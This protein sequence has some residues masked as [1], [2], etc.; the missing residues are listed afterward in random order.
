MVSRGIHWKYDDFPSTGEHLSKGN[1]SAPKK[2]LLR[3][4]NTV[5][6]IELWA[7]NHAASLSRTNQGNLLCCWLLFIHNCLGWSSLICYSLNH[8]LLLLV[9]AASHMKT[10][11]VIVLGPNSCTA[12]ICPEIETG[13]RTCLAQVM[14]VIQSE[15]KIWL[16]AGLWDYQ[17][18]NHSPCNMTLGRLK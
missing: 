18:L 2:D 15:P 7:S 8:H 13:D 11:V 1:C 4:T 14:Y 3:C 6:T 12:S 9:D 10:T 17:N 5:S 16:L